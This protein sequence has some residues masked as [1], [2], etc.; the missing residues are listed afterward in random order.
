MI[1]RAALLVCLGQLAFSA[2]AEDLPEPVLPMG[3]G[4]NIHFTEGHERELDLLAAAGFK[5]VR[6]DFEW[7]GIEREQ[8]QYDWSEYDKLTANLERRGLRP[9]YILDYSN[10]LYERPV[11]SKNA[12]TGQAEH[13]DPASPQHPES[14]AAFARWAGASARHFRGRHIIW[15]LW[16]EPNLFFWKPQPDVGQYTALALASCKAMRQA[17]PQAVL[18]G[19]ATSE[20]PWAF[21]ES[22]FQ[23]GLLAYWDGVSVHPYRPPAS[24]PESV[25]GDYQR[26]RG[27]IERYAPT[28]AKRRI[29]ILSG[30]WGYSSNTKGVSLPNQAAFLVR[31]QLFNLLEG[32][33]ISIWYDWRNDGEDPSENEHNFGVVSH[34]LRPKP[35]YAAI[36]T[37]TRQLSGCRL[38]R[39][40]DTGNGKDYVL[41]L[42][43]AKGRARLAAWTLDEPHRVTLDVPPTPARQLQVVRVGGELGSVEVMS[44]HINLELNGEPQYVI[45]SPR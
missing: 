4:V 31:Q 8:G 34:D 20:F 3:V 26:L 29:P 12:I 36:Q 21:L 37:L 35:A 22:C 1:H 23:S 41:L 43:N 10:P 17:D 2:R 33:P 45:L 27:L 18:V 14:V 30:E 7:A 5:L 24:P 38:G 13:Q 39:R 11:A 16:N 44:N 9:Y 15:E 28:P 6:M 40:C 19:P 32:V 25:A 42:S